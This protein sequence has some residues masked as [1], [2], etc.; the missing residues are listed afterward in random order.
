MLR[1]ILFQLLVMGMIAISFP[2]CHGILDDIYDE[3]EE[4][5]EFGFIRVD[6]ES[7]S[8]TIYVDAHSYTQWTYIDFD[9]KEIYVTN[10]DKEKG[11][12]IES[13]P[14]KWELALHRYDAKTNQ[15]AVLETSY[16]S[17]SELKSAGKL[18]EGTFV[19]DIQDKVAVDMSQMM[20]NNIIY[21]E[22]PVNKEIGKWLNVDT[23]QMPPIY[24]LSNKVYLLKTK[25]GKYAA[26]FLSNYMSNGFQKGFMT[27]DYLYPLE[28]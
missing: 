3:A 2:S 1:K 15:G 22:S 14:E 25:E 13:Q 4:K 21:A 23:S 12:E 16:S 11:K 27:I 28:Y 8:G 7:Q 19:A 20:D 10:I 26:L 17:L 24:T 5:N 18:P 9:G 6:P